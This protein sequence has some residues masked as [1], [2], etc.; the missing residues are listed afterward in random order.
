[1]APSTKLRSRSRNEAS[2]SSA[3]IREI[4]LPALRSIS[5]SLSTHLKPIRWATA[6]PTVVLPV[7]MNPTR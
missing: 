4:G 6:R 1:V 3:K 7:P 2:P 5:W